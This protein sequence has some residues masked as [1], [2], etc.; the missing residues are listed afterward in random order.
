MF[1]ILLVTVYIRCKHK[2]FVAQLIT[3]PL[4]EI[5]LL[6]D[7]YFLGYEDSLSVESQPIFRKRQSLFAKH[8]LIFS[9]LHSI[10]SQEK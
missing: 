7:F 9:G 2:E 10:I 5:I 8:R 4:S 6:E 3:S 1:R